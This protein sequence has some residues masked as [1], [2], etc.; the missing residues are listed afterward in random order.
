MDDKKLDGCGKREMQ[1]VMIYL[2]NG[3]DDPRGRWGN[4]LLKKPASA[5]TAATYFATVRAFFSYLVAEEVIEKS[6][7]DSMPRPINRPDQIMPFT[8]EQI[9]AFRVA[10]KKSRHPRRDE[11]VILMLFDTGLRASEICSLRRDDIDF[12]DRRCSVL[13]KGN[14]R[15]SVYFCRETARVLHNYVRETAAENDDSRAVFLADRGEGAGGGLHRNVLQQLIE[16]LAKTAKIEGV[17][18]S[19]HTFRHTFAI[20]FL[21]AGGNVFTLKELL[22][23]TS[24]TI[25]NRYVALADADIEKQHRLF[26]P[27]EAMMHGP[28][29]RR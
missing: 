17:R 26:S 16:R 25:S 28:R 3:H 18:C 2:R 21:R 23:H 24:L 5:G 15:R 4:P 1:Q 12:Q 10:A 19:P 6:P 8:A 27:V 7:L 13:G 20:E 22:G 9:R 29:K 14:K 11:A